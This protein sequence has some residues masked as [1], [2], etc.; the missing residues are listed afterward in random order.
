MGMSASP[1]FNLQTVV[2]IRDSRLCVNGTTNGTMLEPICENPFNLWQVIPN[3]D[4]PIS[5]LIFSAPS[6]SLRCTFLSLC[7]LCLC[8]AFQILVWEG[9]NLARSYG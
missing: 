2:G 1:C 7:S 3:L 8:G 4:S 6:A 5:N 9:V